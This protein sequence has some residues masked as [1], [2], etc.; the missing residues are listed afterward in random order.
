MLFAQVSL[1]Q[2]GTNTVRISGSYLA[3]GDASKYNNF[4]GGHLGLETAISKN[5]TLGINAG[6]YKGTTSEGKITIETELL[7]FSPEFKYYFGGLFENVYLGIA[8]PSLNKIRAL[9]VSNP[10]FFL[11][12]PK[13]NILGISAS[14]G[15]VFADNKHN[16]AALSVS[17]GRFKERNTTEKMPINQFSASIILGYKWTENK[18]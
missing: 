9:S 6:Y 3:L 7:N 11:L 16:Y 17:F 13:A 1:A 4:Y 14:I 10:N 15:A 8:A 2:I 18:L 12:K 5:A